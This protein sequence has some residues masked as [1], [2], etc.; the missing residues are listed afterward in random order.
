MTVRYALR[1]VLAA[2]G[3]A[4]AVP[5]A[6]A[7]TGKIPDGRVLSSLAG[8]YL[9]GRSAN[10]ARDLR[11]AAAFFTAALANDPENPILM[12]RVL[13]LSIAN[14]DIGT[15]LEFAEKLTKVD[16]RNPMAR[17][18]RG[19]DAIERGALA[20][21]EAEVSSTAL[22]PLT[23]LAGGLLGAWA[24]FGSGETDRALDMIADLT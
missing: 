3:I 19:V 21:A 14:G 18:A 5:P 20:E 23:A 24:V 10:T 13:I 12:D 2:A 8:S 16:P 6:H 11:A 17:F 4:I 15:A 7:E 22:G 1:T 9:A